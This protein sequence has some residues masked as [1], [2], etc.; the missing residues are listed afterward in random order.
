MADPGANA[1]HHL[2]EEPAIFLIKILNFVRPRSVYRTHE[3]MYT[4][5]AQLQI[6]LKA[7]LAVKLSPNTFVRTKR[8]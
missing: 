5:L 2:V 3:N 4:L 7:K 8:L 6:H 1:P